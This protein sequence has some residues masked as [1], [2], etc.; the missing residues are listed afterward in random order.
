MKYIRGNSSSPAFITE[1]EAVSKNSNLV[2]NTAPLRIQPHAT[3]DSAVGRNNKAYEF[4]TITIT[5]SRKPNQVRLVS[6]VLIG[7]QRER[8]RMIVDDT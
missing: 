7:K 5:V 3:V 2:E 4:R 6:V 1:V 8:V